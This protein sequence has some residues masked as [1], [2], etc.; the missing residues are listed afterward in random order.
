MREPQT[1][2]LDVD[3]LS[4]F[5]HGHHA[6]LNRPSHLKDHRLQEFSLQIQEI[7]VTPRRTVAGN[8]HI[9]IEPCQRPETSGVLAQRRREVRYRIGKQ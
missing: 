1:E 9:G 6:L 7:L 2:M 4:D 8:N 5:P 3:R